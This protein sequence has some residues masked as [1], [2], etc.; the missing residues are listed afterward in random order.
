MD[1]LSAIN[2]I[3]LSPID[4]QPQDDELLVDKLRDWAI[5]FADCNYLHPCLID[6]QRSLVCANQLSLKNPKAYQALIEITRRH[7]IFLKEDARTLSSAT[8]YADRRQQ[9]AVILALCLGILIAT[10]DTRAEQVAGRQVTAEITSQLI[11]PS[12][13]L[14]TVRIQ[15]GNH[16]IVRLVRSAPPKTMP[17][18]S[19]HD[20]H[21]NVKPDPHAHVRISRLLQQAYIREPGDP[22][23]IRADLDKMA[24]YYASYPEAIGLL[25]LLEDKELKLRYRK[26]TW[27]TQAHG[28]QLT[29]TSATIFFDPR[30]GARL[31]LHRDCKN[32]PACH[33]SPAD[34]L[35]H[36][37]LHAKIMLHDTDRFIESGGMK[38]T[39]YLFDHEHDVIKMEA[40]LFDAMN[41]TD[42]MSRPL[43]NRHTGRLIKVE[44]SI[45]LPEISFV[46][47][48]D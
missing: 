16:S 12:N 39:L 34:A 26:Y 29:V 33:I 25:K 22:P 24:R 10:T 2:R 17:I 7:D 11:K 27:Q 45:C 13:R 31:W 36:E 14:N 40:T 3:F 8:L 43:R 19:V 47:S 23:T 30:I 1:A 37:L 38:P 46:A 48:A 15:K 20:A 5:R 21:L 9:S 35:L 41:R 4:G 28:N 32:H 44:C 42:G 6:G 18:Q